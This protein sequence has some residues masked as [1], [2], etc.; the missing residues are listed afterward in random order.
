[1]GFAVCRGDGLASAG[2]ETLLDGF[3]EAGR[4]KYQ[5]AVL[6]FTNSAVA[7][8]NNPCLLIEKAKCQLLL[9]DLDQ[10]HRK[11]TSTLPSSSLFA[12]SSSCLN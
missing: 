5:S 7:F 8:R 11:K 10:V 12:S 6:L 2:W 3:V 4:H 1:M 9:G